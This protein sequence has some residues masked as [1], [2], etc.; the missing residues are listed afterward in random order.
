MVERPVLLDDEH[1]VLY[2]IA[3]LEQGCAG[4]LLEGLVDRELIGHERGELDRRRLLVVA[5][6]QE[7]DPPDQAGKKN[8]ARDATAPAMT[9]AHDVAAVEVT[10][11]HVA[12]KAPRSL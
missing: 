3:R 11:V 4:I 12:P 9:F 2:L 1:D 6:V 10:S 5:Q 8:Q 7:C